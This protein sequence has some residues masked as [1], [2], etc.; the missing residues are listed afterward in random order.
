MNACRPWLEAE[1]DAALA[2]LVEDLERV[3]QAMA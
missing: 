2:S 1:L 3:A